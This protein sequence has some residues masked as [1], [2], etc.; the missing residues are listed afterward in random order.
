MLELL[1]LAALLQQL[2]NPHECEHG[3]YEPQHVDLRNSRWMHRRGLQVVKSARE[4]LGWVAG[5]VLEG[6]GTSQSAAIA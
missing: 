1:V 5:R 2:R 6:G 3:R 4:G